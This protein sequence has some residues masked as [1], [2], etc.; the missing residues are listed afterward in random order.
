MP[1]EIALAEIIANDLTRRESLK[2]AEGLEIGDQVWWKSS[3]NPFKPVSMGVIEKLATKTA[4][5]KRDDGQV[6]N[7]AVTLLQK[8]SPS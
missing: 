5:V 7:V 3:R 2:A 1:G 8:G 6:W 4:R